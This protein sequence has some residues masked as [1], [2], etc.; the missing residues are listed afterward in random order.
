LVYGTANGQAGAAKRPKRN[1]NLSHDEL[2]HSASEDVTAALRRTHALM[3]TELSRSRFAQET[4]VE[5]TQALEEL[6]TSYTS[7]DDV[8]SSSKTLVSSLLRSQKSDTW[9]LE[10]SV[11]IL[12]STVIWLV[13]RRLLYGP[14]WWFVWL[15]LK[16]GWWL[17]S[18]LTGTAINMGSVSAVSS[19]VVSSGLSLSSIVA[20]S[21]PAAGIQE[22][23]TTQ[24]TIPT[25]QPEQEQHMETVQRIV[26]EANQGSSENGGAAGKDGSEEE[27]V[28][29]EEAPR[30]PKKRMWEEDKE[31]AKEAAK[32]AEPDKEL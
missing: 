22:P 25:D 29:Q 21:Q 16:M 26:D 27:Q 17:L 19:G 1:E 5:S 13:F 6:S 15:P 12:L 32:E 4:L 14:M 31:V 8:L 30:N 3:S 28:A 7:L 20:S 24:I 2:V 9:Y 11:Y 18:L 10:T 23:S